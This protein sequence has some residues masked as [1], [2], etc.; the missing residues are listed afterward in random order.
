[1]CEHRFFLCRR[2]GNLVGLI[3]D[4]GAPLLCCGREMEPLVPNTAEAGGEKPLP[5]VSV[6]NDRVHVSVGSTAHPMTE[7]HSIQWVYLQTTRGG[8]RKCLHP[9]DAPEAVFALCGDAPVAAYAY[10]GLHGLWRTDIRGR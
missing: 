2:C 5:V 10:C 3:H 4:G 1:M 6:E 7:E 8:Q 9:G